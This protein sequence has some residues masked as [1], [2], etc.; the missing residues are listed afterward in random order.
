MVDA[1]SGNLG[2]YKCEIMDAGLCVIVFRRFYVIQMNGLNVWQCS[3]CIT[4]RKY[5]FSLYPSICVSIY[6]SIFIFFL[7][8]S[9]FPSPLALLFFQLMIFVSPSRVVSATTLRSRTATF[10][11]RCPLCL[12]VKLCYRF[13]TN[14]NICWST[15][16]VTF[17]HVM[18]PL[19]CC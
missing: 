19:C 5:S 4:L 17:K 6:V 14:Y 16:H 11:Y 7:T 18:A 15:C 12:N 2:F 9:L 8:F 10:H 3:C 1:I 13:R